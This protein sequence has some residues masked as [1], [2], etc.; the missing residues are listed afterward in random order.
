MCGKHEIAK[1]EKRG[2]LRVAARVGF[3]AL[4]RGEFKEFGN[5]ADLEAYL[6]DLGEGV[7]SGSY[8]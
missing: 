7:I 3:E 5:I 6:H 4:D 2:A 1:S 8:K